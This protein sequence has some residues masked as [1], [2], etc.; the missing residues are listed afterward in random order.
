MNINVQRSTRITLRHAA[1]ATSP[2]LGEEYFES[3][4]LKVD[5]CR[6]GRN[7]ICPYGE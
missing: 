5:K 2:N 3:N 1:R 7:K 6:E 4:S